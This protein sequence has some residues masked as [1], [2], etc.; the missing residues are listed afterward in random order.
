MADSTAWRGRI[1]PFDPSHITWEPIA[2][3]PGAPLYRAAG[4]ALGGLVVLAGGP[5]NPYNYDGIGYDGAPSSPRRELVAYDAQEGW[6]SL[7]ALPVATMDHRTLGQAG[8]YVFLV[9]G[10]VDGQRVSD[11]VWYAEVN[12][13]LAGRVSGS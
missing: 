8:G 4:G 11:R 2:A 6:V 5:D 12:A 1:D 3:P 13:L 10:M 9:G 7:P